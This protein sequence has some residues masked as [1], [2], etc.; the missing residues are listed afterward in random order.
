M[1]S[2]SKQK[3]SG[4][5]LSVAKYLSGIYKSEGHK[6]ERVPGSGALAHLREAQ[7]LRGDIYSI[8]MRLPNLNIE[9][10]A[11]AKD[12][13]SWESLFKGHSPVLN[14]FI[15]Q[16][17]K[18]ADQDSLDCIFI[19]LTYGGNY[20]AIAQTWSNGIPSFHY[21]YNGLIWRFYALTN[22]FENDINRTCF[23]EWGKAKQI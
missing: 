9:C 14:K 12:K 10:K 1:S 18:D 23:I 8:D 2:K 15:D 11:L 21:E 5:E 19:N 20:I 6:F 17:M 13:W 7:G 3:G 4:W 22:F 16:V